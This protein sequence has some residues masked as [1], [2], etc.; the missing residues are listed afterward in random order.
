MAKAPAASEPLPKAELKSLIQKHG[1]ELSNQLQAHHRTVFPPEAEK[2][3][4]SFSPAEAAALIGIHE[5][6]LRQVASEEA[7]VSP[8]IFF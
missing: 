7:V 6:Y 3:I 8:T 2:T 5:V 4:R 1:A